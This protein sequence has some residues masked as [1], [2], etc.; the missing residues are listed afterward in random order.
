MM[1]QERVRMQAVGAFEYLL[2]S[3]KIHG[4]VPNFM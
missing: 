2:M 4:N 1:L 3:S